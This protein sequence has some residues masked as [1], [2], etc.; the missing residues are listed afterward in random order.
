VPFSRGDTLA[1]MSDSAP[2][3]VEADRLP[4]SPP[5]PP[6]DL[7]EKLSGETELT[8]GQ[9]WH[10]LTI[11]AD[12]PAG[13]SRCFI[14]EH[15]RLL[16]KVVLRILPVTDATEW[17]RGAWERLCS[18]PDLQTVRCISAEEEGGWRYEVSDLP[19][20]MTLHEWLACHRPGFTEI[21]TLVTQLAATLGALHAQG[22]VH[23]NIR[24]S[25]IFIDET[26]PEPL[27]I[28]GGLH[29]AT[30]YTQPDVMPS[31]V[32]PLYAPPEAAGA[33][34]HAAGTRLCAWDWWSTGRVVQEFLLGRHVLGVVWDRDVSRITP[35]LRSKAEQLLL[36]R[37]PAGVRA[38][39]LEYMSVEPALV[40]LLRGLLTG[41]WEA[42]WG[43]DAVRR[44]LKHEPVPDYYDLPRHARFWSWR[45]R[46]FTVAEAAQHFT[47]AEHW[48]EGKDMLF[49]RE[50]PDTLAAFLADSPAHK[51]DSDRLQ[52][53]C[54]LSESAA[55][56]DVPVV[57]RRTVT[58]ALAWLSLANGSG[59][60]TALRIRGE[61]VD[62][63]GLAELLRK[64]GS[65]TAVA[66]FTALLSP[67]VINFVEPLDAS[68]AR[69][70]KSLA[71]KG[72][73]AIQHGVQHGW[74]DPHDMDGRA[75]IFELALKAGALLR[76]PIELL[77]SLYA[78]SSNAALATLLGEKNSS[79]RDTVILAFTAETP[80]RH[81]YI[82]HEEWKQQRCGALQ[83]E[84]D[85]IV[86]VLFWIQLRRLLA[87][88]MMWGAPTPIFAGVVLVL[89]G[90]VAWLSR[91]AGAASAV[92]AAVVLSRVYC[93]W[94]LR[95]HVRKY[96]PSARPWLWADGGLRGAKEADKAVARRSLQPSILET[97][98]KRI[99]GAMALLLTSGDAVPRIAQP[100][101][102]DLWAVFVTSVAVTS[103][104]LGVLVARWVPAPR[105]LEVPAAAGIA[106]E[107]RPAEAA[108][109]APATLWGVDPAVDIDALV[110][111]GR[112]EI[113]DDGFGRQL[114]GPLR[115]WTFLATGEVYPLDII[116]TAPASAEQS[117]F[118]LVS[119]TLVVDP[120][121]RNGVNVLLAISV[122]T[123][124]GF[125]FLVFNTR[126]RKLLDH[127]VRLVREPLQPGAWYQLGSKRI[128]YLG[129]SA[130]LQAEI[131]LA[132][133]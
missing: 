87:W 110:A 34:R 17:R 26:G 31:D 14:A 47:Q 119:G 133:P 79:P 84:A 51:E 114:R 21:E 41:S 50:R 58:A 3:T 2:E 69:T 118:A 89:T 36:E 116:A 40:P 96:D 5:R 8:V 121:P 81:G 86:A 132:P 37:A 20:P 103:V 92:A 93:W 102:W 62:V 100:R 24:P 54:D 72:G 9:R 125:G 61:A 101:W 130:G 48:E 113:I 105:A 123:T 66:L 65:E 85:E 18:M 97:E 67:V 28:L 27:F 91:S 15:E 57:A 107:I 29:E 23:L 60:R 77:R 75:K 42:R 71:S 4:E 19:P 1:P 35:E 6:L 129:V 22:V 56:G 73:E 49:Q 127:T 109:A 68:A 55:W 104:V 43:F 88:T 52:R 74:L 95:A 46:G 80:E 83:R 38:G 122:P 39:A 76:E 7:G 98:L 63:V 70:L 33:E 53:V 59:V 82:T 45:G 44:W 117:A 13:G 90:V 131:S 64:S 25:A 30:L 115:E 111:T 94:R 126:E 16:K 12:Y 11:E 78:T 112:Y 124:R 32:D 120:Y 99:Q 128:G 108:K 10:E 106:P